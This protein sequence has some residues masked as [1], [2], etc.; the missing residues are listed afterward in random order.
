MQNGESHQEPVTLFFWLAKSILSMATRSDMGQASSDGKQKASKPNAASRR[1]MLR[2][3]PQAIRL[4]GKDN[5]SGMIRKEN[6]HW[7]WTA[8]E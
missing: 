8:H 5:S 7:A 1:K 4:N 3:A 2:R 6:Q